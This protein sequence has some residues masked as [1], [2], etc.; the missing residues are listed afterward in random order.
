MHEH[1][2]PEHL[3]HPLAAVCCVCAEFKALKSYARNRYS[4][5]VSNTFPGN[6][7]AV[8][9]ALWPQQVQDDSDDEFSGIGEVPVRRPNSHKVTQR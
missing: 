2:K 9:G 6:D 3:N 8:G 4:R 1:F 5:S 7:S